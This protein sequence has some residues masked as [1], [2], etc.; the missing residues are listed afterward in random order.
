[1]RG[2]RWKKGE[3]GK[4]RKKREADGKKGKQMDKKGNR[5]EIGWKIYKM[6]QPILKNLPTDLQN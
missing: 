3:E 6:S 5:R 2:K 1:M 4:Q